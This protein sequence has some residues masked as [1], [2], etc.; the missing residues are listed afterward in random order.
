MSKKDVNLRQRVSEIIGGD[1]IG[2]NEG[3]RDQA[4]RPLI[5]DSIVLA[6]V[7]SITG[8]LGIFQSHNQ[9]IATLLKWLLLIVP[10]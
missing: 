10:S 3:F 5:K 2:W 4:L 6:E 8:S 9:H 7:S 1:L